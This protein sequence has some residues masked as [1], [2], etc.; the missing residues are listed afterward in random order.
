MSSRD[1]AMRDF[2]SEVRRLGLRLEDMPGGGL[3]VQDSDAFIRFLRSLEPPVTWRDVFPDLPAHWVAGRPET[4]TTPY[5]PFG[6]YDYQEL[7]TGPAVHVIGP[8]A[9]D[10]AW[11]DQLVDAARRAGF[12]VHGAGFI[13]GSGTLHALIILDRDTDAQRRDAFVDWLSEQ[14][15]VE[16]AAVPRAGDE[17]YV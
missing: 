17:D 9:T 1:E 15:V 16:L 3:A 8:S 5:R 2:E 13:E 11:L 12:G 7:P 14:P 6:S 4:W 10:G